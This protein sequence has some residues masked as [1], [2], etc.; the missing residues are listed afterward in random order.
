MAN[1]K[2]R[3]KIEL[4][5]ENV[6]EKIEKKRNIKIPEALKSLIK[7]ANAATP[8][9][10]RFLLQGNE[11]TLGG[12]LSF[13]EEDEQEGIDTVFSAM[14][15][16][17]DND[18]LP[19]AIDPFGNYICYSQSKGNVVCWNHEKLEVSDTGKT[20]GEFIADLY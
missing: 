15:A 8:D 10:H 20:I 9:T 17:N 7:E 11:M 5:N 2:W 19:F 6:F 18:L 1:I 14:E 4:K 13:N 3:F 16:V 12:I